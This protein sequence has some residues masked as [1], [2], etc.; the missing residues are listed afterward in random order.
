MEVVVIMKIGKKGIVKKIRKMVK[1]EEVEE[2]MKGVV[3]LKVVV[4]VMKRVKLKVMEMKIIR[5]V[6]GK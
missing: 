4:E 6:V 2:V 1:D 3:G 5:E